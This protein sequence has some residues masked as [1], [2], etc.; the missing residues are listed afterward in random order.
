MKDWIRET[1]V[2]DIYQRAEQITT[3]VV[4]TSN[5][6]NRTLT[7][8]IDDIVT[9]RIFGIPIMLILLISVFWITISGANIPSGLLATFLFWIEDGL[10][11]IFT[12]LGAPQ[13]LHG[14]IVLGTYRGLAWVVSVMLPPMAIFFPIFTLLED[15]GYLPRIAFNLDQL[16]NKAGAH[17]KQALTMAMGFGCNAAGVIAARIIDSPRE[18]ILAIVTNN[19]VPCNGRFP[20]LIAMATLIAGV[21]VGITGNLIAAI[22]VGGVVILGIIITLLVT[23]KL[24][25]T[26]LKGEPSA[27]TLELPPYRIPQVGRVIVTSIF[28]RTLFVL[29]RAVKVAIPAGA[30]TWILANLYI[31]DIS[32]I[33]VISDWLEPFGHAI[34][35]DGVIILAF[36]LG[37]PANEIVIPIMMMSYLSAGAM[38]E[39]DSITSMGTLLN[40]NGWTW[41]TAFNF[42]LLTL[43]HFPCA[44]TLLTIR[45]ELNSSYWTLMSAIIPTVIGVGLCFTVT[46]LVKIFS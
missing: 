4:D 44:T 22:I 32:L 3:K 1:I 19:F 21:G 17:G 23:W 30:I 43:L 25:R 2:S 39:L 9:S 10:T 15:L 18:R 35:L 12:S 36:I 41:L 34:G 31:G 13:W 7:D 37:L 42:M 28:D 14:L 6:T 11:W 24:S 5:K 45:K 8:R 20:M 29:M 27:F 38:L 33:K 16:F 26:T 40:Q 46:Q